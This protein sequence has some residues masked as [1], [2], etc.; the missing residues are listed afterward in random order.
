MCNHPECGF[1]A[2][3]CG[4]G[5]YHYLYEVPFK[6]NSTITRWNFRLPVGTTVAFWNMSTV[7]KE[8]DEIGLV[9]NDHRDIRSVSL[10]DQH[11]VLTVAVYANVSSA[12]LNMTI[13][14]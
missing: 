13:Q 9:P 10:N 2:G 11:E 5:R 14:V 1:D 4:V 12:V 6:Y 8:F 7:F 3:D